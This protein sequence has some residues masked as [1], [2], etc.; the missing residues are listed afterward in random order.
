MKQTTPATPDESDP[1]RMSVE[2]VCWMLDVERSGGRNVIGLFLGFAGA[3]VN[4]HVTS[5]GTRWHTQAYPGLSIHWL[6]G[7]SGVQEMGPS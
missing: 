6:S 1:R 2:S 3:T 4:E 5:T 7:D